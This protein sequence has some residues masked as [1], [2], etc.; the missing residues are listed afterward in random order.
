MRHTWANVESEGGFGGGSV[1]GRSESQGM[2][3]VVGD[4]SEGNMVSS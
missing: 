2:R 1:G 3:A 4:G